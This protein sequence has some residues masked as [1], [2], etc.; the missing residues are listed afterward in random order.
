MKKLFFSVLAALLLGSIAG[1]MSSP[2]LG[3]EVTFYNASELM[4]DS[5]H[6]EFGSADTQSS[7]RSFRIAPGTSRTLA[8]NHNPGMGFNVVVSYG[9]GSRQEFCALLGDNQTRPRIQ[10]KP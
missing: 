6:L 8:L 4:I 2:V 5:L 9:D 7:I 3:L 1:R 10:L